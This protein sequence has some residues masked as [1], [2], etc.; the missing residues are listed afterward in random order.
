VCARAFRAEAKQKIIQSILMVFSPEPCFILEHICD[1]DL[2]SQTNTHAWGKAKCSRILGLT[3][4]ETEVKALH[5]P[6]IKKWKTVNKA[7]QQKVDGRNF[8]EWM[9][10]GGKRIEI[11]IGFIIFT[12]FLWLWA[13]LFF[14]LL[15]ASVSKDSM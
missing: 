7:S 2:V 6:H 12:F 9:R 14:L 4:L 1:N 10:A 3:L 8:V 11:N 15:R 5:R 13:Q